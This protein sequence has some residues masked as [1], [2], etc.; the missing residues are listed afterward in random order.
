MAE[1]NPKEQYELRKQE[2]L[3]ERSKQ[4]RRQS[5]KRT[6]KWIF[7]LIVIAAAIFCFVALQDRAPASPT[8]LGTASSTTTTITENDWVKGN[9]DAPVTL[10]EYSDFQCPACRSFFPIVK[11]LTNDFGGQLQFAYR[12]FPLVSIHRNSLPAARA[13]EAAGRQGKFWE[14]HD[15]LFE[16]QSDWASLPR[17][18]ST[19]ILY[20][21][22]IGLDMDKFKKD[23]ESDEVS[24]RVN[25]S[26]KDAL[27]LGLNSTPTFIFNGKKIS[28]PRNYNEFKALIQSAINASETK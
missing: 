25:D 12:Y 9:P 19:F 3:K 13:A 28:N 4:S 22:K 15:M 26:L 27:K 7:F 21:E 16:N 6:G 17:P 23:F 14:M 1:L 5:I 18:K 2:K 24:A 20:A 11:Q 8:T 10:V